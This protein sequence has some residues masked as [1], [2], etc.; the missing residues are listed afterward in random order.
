MNDVVKRTHWHVVYRKGQR[1]CID[2]VRY[3]SVAG[4]HNASRKYKHATLLE[5]A[6]KNCDLCALAQKKGK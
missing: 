6:T 3:F 4:A 5:R 2:S 1:V